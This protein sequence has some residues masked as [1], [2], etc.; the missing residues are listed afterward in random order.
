MHQERPADHPEF[1]MTLV[2]SQYSAWLVSGSLIVASLVQKTP[3]KGCQDHVTAEHVS[4]RGRVVAHSCCLEI[5]RASAVDSGR[6]FPV[7]E[8][9][10]QEAG[11]SGLGPGGERLSPERHLLLP[12][13]GPWL[14]PAVDLAQLSP[15][16][17]SWPNL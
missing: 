9:P 12:K 5:R 14:V 8:A 11:P 15:H 17:R 4:V 10:Q 1:L 3:V 13:V 2:V 16:F 7:A 6:E